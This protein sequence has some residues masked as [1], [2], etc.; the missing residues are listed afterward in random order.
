M[1][2][3]LKG[4]KLKWVKTFIEDYFPCDYLGRI[5]VDNL[6]GPIELC[7]SSNKDANLH[8]F[9]SIK[10]VFIKYYETEKSHYFLMDIKCLDYDSLDSVIRRGKSIEY[11]EENFYGNCSGGHLAGHN[12]Y[13]IK[14]DK[15]DPFIRLQSWDHRIVLNSRSKS[16]RMLHYKKRWKG[17]L[18]FDVEKGHTLVRRQII[19]S[20]RRKGYVT[21]Y[22]SMKNINSFKGFFRKNISQDDLLYK[23]LSYNDPNGIMDLLKKDGLLNYIKPSNAD[24]RKAKD[25]KELLMLKNGYMKVPARLYDKGVLFTDFVMSLVEESEIG[26]ILLFIK[27]GETKLNTVIMDMMD[28]LSV[29]D[30]VHYGFVSRS[31]LKEVNSSD[32]SEEI[33]SDIPGETLRRHLQRYMVREKLYNLKSNGDFSYGTCGKNKIFVEYYRKTCKVADGDFFDIETVKDYV[34]MKHELGEKLNLKIKSYNRLKTE[35]DKVAVRYEIKQGGGEV[36]VSDIY[37]KIKVKHDNYHITRIED[38]ESL[39]REGRIM[40]HCVATYVSKIN[41]G[42]SCIYHVD[43]KDGSSERGWTL[44]VNVRN[45]SFV[46]NQMRGFKNEM[47][48]EK[49]YEDI[50][51]LFDSGKEYSTDDFFAHRPNN[52]Q[53]GYFME[54]NHLQEEDL[55]F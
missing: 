36:T 45:N 15:K 25:L 30:M 37:D 7:Y 3:K 8:D 12:E 2:S 38:A 13:H 40:K 10:H 48:P 49:V 28:K 35:H 11:C 18:R 23:C 32:P 9:P 26:K 16:V 21:Q 51:S 47:P 53:R 5:D 33:K 50:L 6:D 31:D 24:R 20:N 43:P 42:T 19:K 22:L 1:E 44:E 14:V 34:R 46:L 54:L 55:P 27:E 29:D 41:N 39:I 17:R 52:N 4:E